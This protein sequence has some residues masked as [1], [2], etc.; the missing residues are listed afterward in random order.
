[1]LNLNSGPQSK[2][3]I[4]TIYFVFTSILYTLWFEWEENW[5]KAN[6]LFIKF[7]MQGKGINMIYVWSNNYT[8]HIECTY[9]VRCSNP[10]SLTF[11]LIVGL[12]TLEIVMFCETIDKERLVLGFTLGKTIEWE[13]ECVYIV[14]SISKGDTN[15]KFPF[16]LWVL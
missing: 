3:H 16:Q 15:D 11:A 10:T 1:M 7:L 8:L 2:T 12:M 13:R 14:R 9:Y 4:L 6:L 5:Y